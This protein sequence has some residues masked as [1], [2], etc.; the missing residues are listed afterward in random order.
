MPDRQQGKEI[1]GLFNAFSAVLTQAAFQ[2]VASDYVQ[3]NPGPERRLALT[4][5]GMRA[6]TAPPPPRVYVGGPERHK[7]N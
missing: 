3:H 4:S 7:S 5:G 6:P 1:V 2:I